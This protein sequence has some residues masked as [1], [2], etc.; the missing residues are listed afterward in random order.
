MRI[1]F[2]KGVLELCVLAL[3]EKQDR[4]GYDIASAFSDEM[5]IS[6]G[7]VYPILRRLSSELYLSSYLSESNEGPPR[8]Y[9]T[10]TPQGRR[11]LTELRAEWQNFTRAVDNMLHEE[12]DAN[13]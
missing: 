6:D 5:E 4:Y 1:Q 13:D 10:I 3:L 7:T 8:K 11:F 12:V 2:K 9:Y